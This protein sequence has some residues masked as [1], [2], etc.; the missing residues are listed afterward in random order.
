MATET[1]RLWCPSCNKW[2]VAAR[3]KPNRWGHGFATILTGGAWGVAWVGRELAEA[4]AKAHRPGWRCTQ[5]GYTNLFNKS[6]GPKI[7]TDP[8]A[9]PKCK[10]KR[11]WNGE[12]CSNCGYSVHDKKELVASKYQVIGIERATLRD[13]DRIIEATTEENAKVKAELSGI[14]VTTI[15]RLNDCPSE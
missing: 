14:V 11:W 9:C 2:V 5:C 1:T 8:E 4:H 12:N 3:S 13:V 6:L 10:Y 7:T 15:I